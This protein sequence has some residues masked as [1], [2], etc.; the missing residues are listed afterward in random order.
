MSVTS[1][2]L[3]IA[4]PIVALA[5]AGA[6][7]ASNSTGHSGGATSLTG[8]GST[9]AQP[10]YDTWAQKYA[11][12]TSVQVSYAAVGS[13]AGIQQ[14]TAK[15]VDFGA[16]DAPM[17]DEELAKAPGILHIPTAFGS[18]VITYNEPS[19][20]SFRLSA[21]TVA[22]I[23]LKKITKWNDPLIKA[24]NPGAT[25]PSTAITVVHRSDSSGTTNT[26]T[27]YLQSASSEWKASGLG[28]GKTVA[29]PQGEVGGAGNQGVAS[30]L[31]QTPGTI[32]YVELAF[33]ITGKLP[34]TLVKN[35]AGIFIEPSAESTAA[36]AAG[37]KIPADLRFS[38]ADAP[39]RGAYPICTA[40]W[41]LVYKTQAD[42]AKG[43]ALVA[44]LNW[45]L[46]DGQQYEGTLGYVPLPADLLAKAKAQVASIVT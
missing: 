17:K 22:G 24:D 20:K 35:K 40:T 8:A 5:L 1:K 6:A 7:C 37:A 44:F 46:T 9:F 42:P 26:F 25:L 15:T 32:G 38:I 30:A 18:V 43:K 31:K 39:G 3:K 2:R 14:I 19:V 13:G 10:L 11:E 4:A 12:K 27:S 29:W 33:A 23:F 16:T 41:I 21:N 28:K 34:L 36:A 45:A